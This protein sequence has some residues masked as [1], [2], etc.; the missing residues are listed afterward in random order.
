MCEVSLIDVGPCACAPLA[1]LVLCQE[2]DL[3]IRLLDI[4]DTSHGVP[5]NILRVTQKQSAKEKETAGRED[6]GRYG[7]AAMQRDRKKR[8]IE[9]DLD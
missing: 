2:L 8:W 3:L 1:C 6:G 4:T 7:I 9:R 5:C